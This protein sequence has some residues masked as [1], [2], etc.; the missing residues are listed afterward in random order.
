[1]QVLHR[2]AQR[3]AQNDL[4]VLCASAVGFAYFH[5]A[6]LRCSMALIDELPFALP[7][8]EVR[9]LSVTYFGDASVVRAVRNFSF[10][11]A[12]GEIVALVG[13]TGCGKSTLASALLGLLDPSHA[14]IG[15]EIRLEGSA[16][17]RPGDERAWRS[18]RG[19]SVGMVFQ[20]PRGSLNPVL[21]AGAQLI[22]AIRS[23][24]PVRQREARRRA[25]E[26]LKRV[27]L[28]D[29]EFVMCRYPGEL[30]GGMCQR[31]GIAL[32]VCGN[33]TLLVADEPTS[34][35]DPTIQAQILGLLQ[36]MNRSGMTVLLISHNLE[37][38]AGYSD[39]IAVMYHGCLV[40]VGPA[41]RI[42]DSPQHPY[43][44]GLIRANPGFIAPGRRLKP[45]PGAPPG[46]AAA[47][48]GCSFAPRCPRAD[49]ACSQSEPALITVSTGHQAACFHAA[50]G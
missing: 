15:G 4:G 48:S 42:L 10:E 34:A 31:I 39:R 28:G 9:R 50:G 21:T 2:R 6:P 3:K 17:P 1:M 41:E 12:P 37:L 23:H 46:G 47:F 8:L 13:E 40:E 16:L 22:D 18:L 36:E 20:D 29:P 49:A 45:I 44:E 19:T 26:L 25:T 43:T 33:P 24:G 35:L 32:A 38:I 30:S 11:A 14:Y 7:F 5:S 27:G